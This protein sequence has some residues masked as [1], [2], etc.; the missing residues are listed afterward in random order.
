M[1]KSPPNYSWLRGVAPILWGIFFFG[2]GLGPFASAIA[3]LVSAL[4]LIGV[5]TV[6]RG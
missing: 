1:R 5:V 6:I 2:F 4:V 3:M